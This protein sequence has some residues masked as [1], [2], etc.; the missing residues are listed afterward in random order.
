MCEVCAAFGRG[1][2]WTARASGVPDTIE[3]IDLRG[4]RGERRSALRLINALLA[5]KGLRADDWDGDAYLVTAPS[6]AAV[7]AA[8]L[9]EVWSVAKRLGG[10]E[11]DPPADDFLDA[12][13]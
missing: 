9:A 6:G 5:P 8:H 4:Y 12:A 2:H 3:S 1:N 10:A 11:V 13:R 7:K